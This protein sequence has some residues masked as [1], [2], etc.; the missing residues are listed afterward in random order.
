MNDIH[1]FIYSILP[2]LFEVVPGTAEEV[3]SKISIKQHQNNVN[4]QR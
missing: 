1:L 4:L 3:V 2:V